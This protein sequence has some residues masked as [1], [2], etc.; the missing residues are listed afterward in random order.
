MAIRKRNPRTFFLTVV[1]KNAKTDFVEGDIV[2]I[3]DAVTK[4]VTSESYLY[5]NNDWYTM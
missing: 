2:V 1:E 5:K 4:K 3:C